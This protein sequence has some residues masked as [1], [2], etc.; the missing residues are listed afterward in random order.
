MSTSKSPLLSVVLP[1]YNA[2]STIAAA[3]DSVLRQTWEDFELLVVNDGSKDRTAEVVRSIEDPRLR[4][5]DAQK[6]R[7]V[8]EVLNSALREARG[9]FIARHD[10]DDLSLPDRFRA[11]LDALQGDPSLVAVGSFLDVV[12]PSGASVDTWTYPMTPGASRWQLL[13][14]TPV[15]HSVVLYRRDAVL[16]VGGYF[17]QFRLAE[18]YELWSRL[19]GVGGIASLPRPLLRYT[20]SPQGESRAKA[21]E[22]HDVHIRISSA[23]IRQLL[24]RDVDRDT[25]WLLAFGTDGQDKA[26]SVDEVVVAGRVCADLYAAFM[27][28]YGSA[29]DTK[30][31]AADIERRFEQLAGLL[32]FGDLPRAIRQ[33]YAVAPPGIL[34]SRFAATLFARPLWRGLQSWRRRA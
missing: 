6:N 32:P 19:A 17:E 5:I 4:L 34:G 33:L 14:K 16:D 7:G 18:D 10:A 1:A 13:F 26:V 15:A 12:S 30:F 8:V 31:M 3:I 2:E 23:N 9:A 24:E 29:A 20:L 25:V 11:Q 27:R 21:A 28:R 22:Q